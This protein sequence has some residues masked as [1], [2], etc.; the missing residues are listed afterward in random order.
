MRAASEFLFLGGGATAKLHQINK[1]FNRL[2]SKLFGLQE[3]IKFG[4][5]VKSIYALF[6]FYKRLTTWR[7]GST[8]FKNPDLRLKNFSN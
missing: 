6:P 1:A 5:R 7:A 4:L 3:E 8:F 2:L